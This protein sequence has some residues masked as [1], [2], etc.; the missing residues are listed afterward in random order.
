LVLSRIKR[1]FESP[2]EDW[3]KKDLKELVYS[4]LIDDKSQIF[5]NMDK[6]YI[7]KLIARRDRYSALKIWN[8]LVLSIWYNYFII[9]QRS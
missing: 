3:L 2:V 7:E 5:S 9:E 8:L 4:N 6:Y 1:G